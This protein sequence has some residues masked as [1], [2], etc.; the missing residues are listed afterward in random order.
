[1]VLVTGRDNYQSIGD[2]LSLDLLA[3]PELLQQP[4]YAALSAARF[5][6]VSGLNTLADKGEFEAIT[7]K[8][9]GGLDGETDRLAFY[10]RALT[11]LG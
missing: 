3:H 1:M 7:L 8:I 2:A 9:N 4:E 11:V 5:W 10:Q 6:S